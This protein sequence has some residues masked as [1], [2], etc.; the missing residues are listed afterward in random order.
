MSKATVTVTEQMSL[1]QF[2]D[3]GPVCRG[4]RGQNHLEVEVAQL[5]RLSLHLL[6]LFWDMCWHLHF[7]KI[8]FSVEKEHLESFGVFDSFVVQK[9]HQK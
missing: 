6:F 4:L 1:D 7:S 3:K 8:A 9:G 2:L 5:S